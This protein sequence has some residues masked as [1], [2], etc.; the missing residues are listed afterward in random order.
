M[1]PGRASL[2]AVLQLALLLLLFSALLGEASAVPAGRSL[3]QSGVS[4]PAQIP[5]CMSRRCTTR[6][7]N[8]QE[9]YVCLRCQSGYMPVKGS[10]G[11]SVVQCGESKMT[12]YRVKLLFYMLQ[13]RHLPCAAYCRGVLLQ[14]GAFVTSF[15]F[16]MRQ[17]HNCALLH[18]ITAPDATHTRT[19][20]NVT[21]CIATCRSRLQSALRA[22]TK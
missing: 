8:S 3:Q 12:L 11:K 9:T 21:P 20:A 6:I 22:P 18:C 16:S 4:C 1:M 13:S 2:V 19:P 5:A 15:D 14:G 10:D 17:H 7:L